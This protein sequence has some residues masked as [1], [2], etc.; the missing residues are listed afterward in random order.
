MYYTC[1]ALKSDW[2]S[3]ICFPLGQ[4]SK[5]RGTKWDIYYNKLAHFWTN[6]YCLD[7]VYHPQFQ[8]L[9]FISC[10]DKFVALVV[11]LVEKMSLCLVTQNVTS[12]VNFVFSSA[13]FDLTHVSFFSTNNGTSHVWEQEPIWVLQSNLNADGVIGWNKVKYRLI[14]PCLQIN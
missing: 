10:G 12:R 2:M 13:A 6:L 8:G 3:N 4:K 11:C 5:Q 14:V 1:W 9:S 7:T